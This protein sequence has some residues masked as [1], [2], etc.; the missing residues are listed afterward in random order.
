MKTS[1]KVET[2]KLNSVT[3]NGPAAHHPDW[4]RLAVTVGVFVL[5][6]VIL[7]FLCR[8]FPPMS[9]EKTSLHSSQSSL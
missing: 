7:I 5:L 2:T 6:G 4:V 3:N 8:H 1:K 9:S